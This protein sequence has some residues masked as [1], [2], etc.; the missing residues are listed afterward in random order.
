MMRGRKEPDLSRATRK[1][2]ETVRGPETRMFFHVISERRT[3]EREMSKKGPF[4]RFG[5]MSQSYGK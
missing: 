5:T 1:P 2:V 3:F 4:S